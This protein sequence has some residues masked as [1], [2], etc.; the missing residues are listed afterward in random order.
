MRTKKVVLHAKKSVIYYAKSGAIEL[1]IE[2]MVVFDPNETVLLRGCAHMPCVSR[3]L[4]RE[5]LQV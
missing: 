5:G 3:M 4:W 2:W 1:R